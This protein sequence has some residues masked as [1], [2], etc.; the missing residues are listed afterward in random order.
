MNT[1][2]HNDYNYV[3]PLQR[4][5]WQSLTSMSTLKTIQILI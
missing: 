3:V 5:I 1:S 2:E 4:A